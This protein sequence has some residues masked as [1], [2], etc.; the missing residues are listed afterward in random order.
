VR[1]FSHSLNA[2][3]SLQERQM[4]DVDMTGATPDVRNMDLLELCDAN[5]RLQ[6]ENAE[7]KRKIDEVREQAI[8]DPLTSL[9]NRRFLDEMLPRMLSQA[10]RLN[11]PVT[12]AMAD[13]DRFK[14]VN[15]SHGH[16]VGDDLLI[17]VASIIQRCARTGDIAC[18]FGGEEF[19]LALPGMQLEDASKR[20]SQMRDEVA[21][22]YVKLGQKM[23]ARTIS[24]GIASYPVHAKN[25]HDL[26]NAADKALSRAKRVGR[27]RVC[28]YSTY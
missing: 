13:I 4:P 25:M 16:Q 21:R 7:L 24:I 15:D 2:A 11:Y 9:Y 27:N 3:S 12:V 20:L 28:V 8:R 19:L 1:S 17:K 22:E 6:K 10:L 5:Q 26:I 23:L 18:R 14:D